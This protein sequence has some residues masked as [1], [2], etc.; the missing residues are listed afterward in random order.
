[1]EE[2]SLKKILLYCAV[3]AVFGLVITL[4]PLITLA[5]ITAENQ[6]ALPLAR[7]VEFSHDSKTQDYS[8]VD[9][10]LFA[11]CFVIAI[12]AYA[13]SK[14]KMPREGQMWIKPY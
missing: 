7:S 14:R 12:A 13:V 9:V 6:F 11:I 4:I 3:A 2:T 5:K 1:M 10:R 8:S